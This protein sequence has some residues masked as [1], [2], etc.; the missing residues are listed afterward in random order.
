M[1]YWLFRIGIAVIPHLPQ[2]LVQRVALAIGWLLWALLAGLRHQ[3]REN[4][5]HVPRLANHPST[6]RRAVQ[7]VF[8]NSLL[9]YVDFFRL[10]VITKTE[11]ADYW[12]VVGLEQIDAALAKGRGCI[13]ISGHLGNF[14][15]AMREF[16]NLGYT[17]TV[18]QEH[19]KPERLHQ[20]IMQ[21]RSAPGVSWAPVDAPSGLRQLFAAL[22]RNE[23]VIMPADRDIQ[24][25]GE[26]VPL[27]GA[28]AR[29]PLGGVQL[30]ERTGA[31]LLGVF[32]HRRGLA[33]GYG[34]IVPLPELTPEEEAVAPDPL[35]RNLRR[36][37]KLLEQ[38]IE[39]DPDQWVIFQP[40][41]LPESA[42][43]PDGQ[44]SEGAAALHQP[45]APQRDE[46]VQAQQLS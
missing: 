6:L 3:V 2:R 26:I 1:K 38:Q 33:H 8:G 14:D 17:L 31:A 5:R 39:R 44:H 13:L 27:F 4:L 22:R 11:L 30:A 45:A 12:E 21:V 16:I 19:L 37:A 24:G 23:V 18:T 34:E 36:V 42:T 7:R 20:L 32:P 10:P 41:W 15:Y 25:H 40:I 9:N 43:L 35:H 46:Q 28:P 29:L